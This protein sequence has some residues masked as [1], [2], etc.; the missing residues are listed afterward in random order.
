MNTN[1]HYVIMYGG[2]L[3]IVKMETIR[4]KLKAVDIG[5][6]VVRDGLLFTIVT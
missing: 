1:I 5:L 2:D 3:S 4:Q 6:R